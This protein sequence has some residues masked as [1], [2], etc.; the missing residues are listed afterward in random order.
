MWLS[1]IAV[2]VCASLSNALSCNLSSDL[3]KEIRSYQ[4]TV[5]QIINATTQGL[6]KGK[7]YDELAYFVD[8]FGA[9]Q[10]GSQVLEDSIDYLLD[11]MQST[12]YDLDNVHGENVTIPHWIRGTQTCEM[13]S[14]RKA[15]IPVLTLGGSVSTLANGFEAEAIV[16]K[17]FDEL[18]RVSDKVK[19]KIVVYNNEYITYGVSV[20]YRSK[21]PSKAAKYGAIA[22]LIRSVT[23][24]S[25]NTLHTGQ[26]AYEDS[27]PKI[28]AASITRE[29]ANMFQ[30]MQDRG[31]KIVLKLNI[32]TQNLDPVTSRNVVAEIKGSRD[33]EKVV[34]VSGHIDSWDV[35]VGAMDDGGGAFISWYALRVLKALGLKPKRT[36]RSVLWTAEEPGLIGVQ[37]YGQAHKDE[38]DKHIFVMESDE[39]VFTPLGI[40]YVAGDE[41]GCILEEILKLLTPIDATQAKLVEFAGSDITIWRNILPTANLLS[42]NENYFWYHHSEADT[43]DVLDTAALDKATAL[44]ASVAYILADLNKDFPRQVP[45]L[46][47]VLPSVL[48]V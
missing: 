33:P 45:K 44:W 46:N 27:I 41:G 28:A 20:A 32:Q 2:L 17:D 47:I 38:L 37:A 25:L 29:H 16:V 14:P 43:M 31:D 3:L 13:L 35:G 39:G 5:D 9:R 18:D 23:P 40:E 22:T 34:L 6:F 19:G 42:R 26:T 48:H 4:G 15:N 8:K 21:G 36:L 12:G 30:R 1:T 24:F 11:L 10:A 7:T